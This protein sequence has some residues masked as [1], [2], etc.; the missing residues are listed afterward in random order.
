[1]T[2]N[3]RSA[4]NAALKSLTRVL[5]EQVGG[6]DAAVAVL[7][8]GGTR[9][10]RRSQVSN[11]YNPHCNQFLP[12]DLLA[13]LEEVADE[14]V[15]TT[16]LAR[17]AGQVMTRPAGIPSDCLLQDLAELQAEAGDVA[18]A[19]ADGMRDGHLCDEDLARLE[20]EAMQL[21]GRACEALATLRALRSPGSVV[22]ME[23]RRLRPWQVVGAAISNVFQR[24]RP[25]P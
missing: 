1:M 22:V 7:N 14:P 24:A 18:R 19:V 2:R 23:T 4:A 17:R 13:R 10:V 20:R 8:A 12:V 16:E 11:Y 25:R 9:G 21:H 15:I 3:S 6:I 5:I